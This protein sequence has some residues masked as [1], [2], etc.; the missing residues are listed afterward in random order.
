[1]EREVEK[2]AKRA[3]EEQRFETEGEGDEVEGG[4]AKKQKTEEDE[5]GVEGEECRS[6]KKQK[7]EQIG[8]WIQQVGMEMVEEEDEDEEEWREAWDDV[9]GGSLKYNGVVEA[10]REEI[11]YMVKRGIWELRP[12]AE[13]WERAGKGPTGVRWVDTNKGTEVES[14]V[15]CR[16]VARDFRQKKDK[17]REDLFAETPPL[18]AIRMQLSKAVTR[19]MRGSKRGC[20]KIMFIDAKKAY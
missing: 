2:L 16:L 8:R 4:G 9:R 18:E 15:R 5:S 3:M 6:S 7:I 12:I 17:G 20:R 19:R 10:R 11:G 14:D 1:L 13:C